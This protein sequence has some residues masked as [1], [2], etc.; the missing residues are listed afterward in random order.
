MV[1]DRPIHASPGPAQVWLET[2]EKA[3]DA[4]CPGGIPGGLATTVFSLKPGGSQGQTGGGSASHPRAAAWHGAQRCCLQHEAGG[5][6][7]RPPVPAALGPRAVAGGRGA[8]FS[9]PASGL[10]RKEPWTYTPG[11]LAGLGHPARGVRSGD[12]CSTHL[13]SLSLCGL[14]A[15][16]GGSGTVS[17]VR[18]TSPGSWVWT[19]APHCLTAPPRKLQLQ[20]PERG[21]GG[22]FVKLSGTEEVLN[23]S[24][25]IV[26]T[27]PTPSVATRSSRSLIPNSC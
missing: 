5:A 22:K 1:E 12:P 6:Q 15:S 19:E 7:R 2:Q 18:S 16:G 3:E 26:L 17:W 11:P 20:P 13:A 8:A 4:A 21:I 10:V 25:L 24:K 9:S 23:E 14:L 27:L